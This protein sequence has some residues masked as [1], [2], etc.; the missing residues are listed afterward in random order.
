MKSPPPRLPLKKTPLKTNTPKP[1]ESHLNTDQNTRVALDK[2]LNEDSQMRDIGKYLNDSDSLDAAELMSQLSKP[3]MD[4]SKL[5]L[6]LNGDSVSGLSMLKDDNTKQTTSSKLPSMKLM[7]SVLERS[8][9]SSEENAM[10]ATKTPTKSA[11]M[12][13]PLNA[14]H[15]FESPAKKSNPAKAFQ[16]D[17]PMMTPKGKRTGFYTHDGTPIGLDPTFRP[18]Q[19]L[20]SPNHAGTVLD[21][22]MDNDNSNQFVYVDLNVEDNSRQEQIPKEDPTPPPLTPSKNSAMFGGEG[23]ATAASDHLEAAASI[24]A[25]LQSPS[26]VETSNTPEEK[27]KATGQPK[28]L[29][30]AAV[31]RVQEKETSGKKK[32]I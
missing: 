7:E 21:Y 18:D 28:T 9:G 1:Y 31:G 17:T 25:L 22:N 8:S 19:S 30:S 3:G 15:G 26:K 16:L 20:L 27:K 10:G 13:A 14:S 6:S 2:M 23:T 5:G 29:F 32:S 12:T 4:H 24:F 11:T